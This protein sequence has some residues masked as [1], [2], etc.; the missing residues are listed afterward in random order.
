[1]IVPFAGLL[2]AYTPVSPMVAPATHLPWHEVKRPDGTSAGFLAADLW[3]DAKTGAHFTL[4][5]FPAG[6]RESPHTHSHDM[7]VVVLEGTMRYVIDG[8]ESADLAHD[9]AV[10]IPAN[11]PHYAIC[12]S[13]IPCEVLV[14]QDGAMDMKPT[15]AILGQR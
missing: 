11:V 4:A 6:F 2:F 7:R 1:M 5:K 12:Q 13:A 10:A 14:Q 15:A 8:V 3:I 9:S